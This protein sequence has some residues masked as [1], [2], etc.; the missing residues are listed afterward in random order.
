MLTVLSLTARH[1]C[2]CHV[3]TCLSRSWTF[4]FTGNP[5]LLYSEQLKATIIN[6]NSERG[7]AFNVGEKGETRTGLKY[8][9]M[10]V[11]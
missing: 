9:R 5:Q 6:I 10:R 7:L 11:Y 2:L 4:F 3:E 1:L 8:N